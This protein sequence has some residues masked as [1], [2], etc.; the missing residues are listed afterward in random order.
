[1]LI[2][3]VGGGQLGRMLGLAGVAIGHRF[4]FLD[5]DPACPASA[6]GEVVA[7]AFDDP[8]SVAA[9]AR[10]LDRAT[11]EFATVPAATLGAIAE[12]APLAPGVM[13]LRTAQDRILEKEFFRAHGLRVQAFEA[14]D[15]EQMLAAACGRVGAPGVLKTRTMGYDGKGQ[16]VVR[17]A[18]D[19][20]AAWEAVGRV[21]CIYEAFVPF[22]SEAS[23]VAVRSAG[24]DV[25]AYPLCANEH[26]GGILHR[27][28]APAPAVDAGTA[29]EAERATCRVLEALGHV[30]VLAI[31]FFV[32][33]DGLVANEMAPRVHNSGHWTIE[34]AVTSQ[35][36]NHVRAV[37]GEPLGSTD[38]RGHSAMVNLVGRM[39][40]RERV[41]AVPGAHLHDYGKSPRA[42]RKLGHVSVCAPD[43]RVRDAQLAVLEAL[44]ARGEG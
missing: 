5:P 37:A 18:A 2:G 36:E 20:P 38:A 40:P 28:V 31:E 16:A 6:V 8:A 41:L 32:T 11:F 13:S 35:F 10:G 27:T 34:G 24:G 22:T 14:V 39:P 43:A 26:R 7:G 44:V 30:G 25:R 4:R 1:M 33:P 21:P 17:S 29:R 23:V 9:F 19:V 12:Q 42:G 15:S 3:V